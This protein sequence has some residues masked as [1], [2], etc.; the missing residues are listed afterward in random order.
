MPSYSEGREA[1]RNGLPVS[2]N[3]YLAGTPMHTLW[4]EGWRDSD[5]MLRALERNN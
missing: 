4:A 3:P 1:R 2:A 5:A